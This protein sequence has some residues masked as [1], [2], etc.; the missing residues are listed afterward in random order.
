M[1]IVAAQAPGQ[2]VDAVDRDITEALTRRLLQAPGHGPITTTTTPGRVLATVPFEVGPTLEQAQERVRTALAGFSPPGAMALTIHPVDLN[3]VPVVTYVVAPRAS[4]QPAAARQFADQLAQELGAV[5]GVARVVTMGADAAGGALAP[6]RVR[7]DGEP[8]IALEVVKR[9]G[10]NTLEVS[11]ALD[12]VVRARNGAGQARVLAVRAEAPFIREATGSTIEALW[13]AIS[14]SV[15]VI[16]PFLRSVPATAI[17]ALA[18]PTSLLGTFLVMALA[19][20][21]LE[22]ITLLALALVIGIIIDDAIV[23]VENIAR[24]LPDAADARLAAQRATDEIGLT[25]TA[26]TLTIVAVFVPVALMGDV[27]GTF[28]RPFGLTISAA[29]LTSLLVARTLT[30]VL[31]VHWLKAG[32]VHAQ[33]RAWQRVSAAYRRLL[34]IALRRPGAVLLAAGVSLA[35]SLVLI[36]LIPQGFIPVLDRGECVVRF[37]LAPGSSLTDTDAVAA[38]LAAIAR[39]EPDVASV[40]SIAGDATA[41][42]DRGVLQVALRPDRTLT[43]QMIEDRLRREFAAQARARVSVENVPIIAVAAP[44]PLEIALTSKDAAALAQAA[45]RVLSEVAHWPGVADAAI[46]GVGPEGDGTWLRRNGVATALIR[47]NLGSGAAL[48]TVGERIQSELPA[49]LP[50][51]ITLALGG[52]SDQAQKVFDRFASALAFAFAGVLI[53]LLCLFRSWQD[54]VA[55]AIALPLSA[56]GALLGLFIARSDFGIVSLLGL[57]FLT[58]LAGKNAIILVDRINQLRRQGIARDLAILEAGSVRLR[59]ILMTTAAAV[60]GMLPIA[61]G[62]GV[63]AE[64]RAPM[65][66]A[67]IGGLLTSTVLSLVVVPVVYQLFDRLAPRFAV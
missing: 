58:G 56:V 40:L 28:F 18:I 9:A 62:L 11:D 17:S 14:L 16:Y 57:V 47:A 48:G 42:A 39:A 55:I 36:P 44:Q 30:P 63:G 1:V 60:L 54:P 33:P 15:L 41:N 65:A 26:A 67:I 5:A 4:A 34:A 32:A 53:V 21:K 51:G 46:A 20:F 3:E 61:L 38:Q 12:K 35:A 7:F 22:T 66:T 29:V 10:A 2:A 59:P 37:A 13:G 6:T 49:L 19:G 43:T 31:A 45:K 64:L 8:A 23:D 50:P 52:E 27:V 25:V 24:I